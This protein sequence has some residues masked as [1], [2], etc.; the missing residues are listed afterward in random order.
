MY[1]VDK[2]QRSRGKKS[3]WFSVMSL[4]VGRL[5]SGRLSVRVCT[6]LKRWRWATPQTV[7]GDCCR[8]ATCCAWRWYR[9]PVISMASLDRLLMG[10][11]S[12]SMVFFKDA[13][14]LAIR[15]MP[16]RPQCA[17][18]AKNGFLQH[19]A[20]PD[21]PDCLDLVNTGRLPQLQVAR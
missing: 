18:E 15:D 12:V 8:L 1:V 16:S 19:Q 14:L 21:K 7:S 9:Q 20:R 3:G 6:T 2:R 10:D 11:Q 17:I 4:G 13:R 5:L